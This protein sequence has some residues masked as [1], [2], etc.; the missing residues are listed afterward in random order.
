MPEKK[1]ILYIITKGNWGGAQ[2]YVYDLATN[3]PQDKF[4]PVVAFGKEGNELS[5]KLEEK[6]IRFYVLNNL[7]REI[8]FFDE[9]KVCRELVKIIKHERP[10]VVHLN[11]S[12]IG[13]LGA[14]AVW[15]LRFLNFFYF[16]NRNSHL[17]PRCIFTSHGWGFYEKHRPYLVRLFYYLSHWITI[18]LC[19]QTIAVSEKTKKDIEFLPFLKNK[20]KTI[21]NGIENFQTLPKEK[22]VKF[23]SNTDKTVIFSIAELHKNK[24]L[25]LAIK[26]ISLL[27]QDIQDK[28]LYVIAGGGEEKTNLDKLTK[29]LKIEKNIK[30]LDFV[31]EASKYLTGA[32][33]FL[34]PSRTE[35]LPYALLEA[36]LS[37][38]PI[39]ATSV[40]GIPEIIHDMQNG[41][42]IHP[43]NP[44]E[45]AEA[46][47]Y[48][49]DHPEKQKEFGNE[50]KKTIMNFFTLNQMISETISIYSF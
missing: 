11:S 12:K 43:R 46:I 8:K 41:I 50:I 32:K 22:A 42:L 13:G 7:E 21:H 18:I 15:Y 16:V 48:L 45:I 47:I 17:V 19:D 37:G 29:D 31:P 27:P 36:G 14:L 5:K 30:F 26:A 3:L 39:I 34:M 10:D 38:L 25:D 6:K 20:I 33:F 28:I 9:F 40:G 4:E 2:R 35:N 49:L 44:K 23:L 24:G 1:K